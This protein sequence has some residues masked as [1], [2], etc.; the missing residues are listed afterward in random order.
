M[1]KSINSSAP[2]PAKRYSSGTP[3][4][5]AMIFAKRGFRG[6]DKYA[7]NPVFPTPRVPSAMGRMGFHSHP[8]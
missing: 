1:S 2:A 3:G 4:N 6:Q 8:V 5:F 7:E